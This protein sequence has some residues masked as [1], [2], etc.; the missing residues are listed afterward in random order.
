M[1]KKLFFIYNPRS[2]K[3]QIRGKLYGILQVFS[4]AGYEMTVYP[5]RF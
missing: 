4:E 5:T 3:E 1:G 2:G